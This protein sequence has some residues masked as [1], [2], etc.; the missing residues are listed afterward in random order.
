MAV[1]DFSNIRKSLM[2]CT[3]KN[4]SLL[5]VLV[6]LS[7][8]F[9][10]ASPQFLTISNILNTILQSSV[11]AIVAI[12]VTFIVIIG[13]IDLSPGAA[14]ALV[15]VLSAGMITQGLPVFVVMIMAIL[16][17]GAIGFFNG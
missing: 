12:G 3:R 4:F 16:I 13:G 17:G 9:S 8:Y 2:A 7:T 10:L 14:V 11:M 6:L 15:G 5:A 1:I